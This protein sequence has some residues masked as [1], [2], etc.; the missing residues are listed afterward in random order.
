MK[1]NDKT[2]TTSFLKILG[3]EKYQYIPISV[4]AILLSL[5]VGALV[6]ALLG[7]NP[8]SAYLNLL[9]GSGIFPKAKYAGGKNMLTD[10]LSFLDYWTPM[11][12]AALAVA[13]ARAIGGEIL[14]ADSRQVYRGMDIGTGKDI[15]EYTRGNWL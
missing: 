2:N 15:A 3:N 4:F 1:R 8:F 5:L 6:I 9:Q 12:L 10:F 11:I 14:S 13:V 7:K